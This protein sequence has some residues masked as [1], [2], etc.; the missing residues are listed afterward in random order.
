MTDEHAFADLMA[1]L[2]A[3][4]E[5]VARLVVERF[6]GRLMALARRRLDQRLRRKVDPED[7]LQSVYKSFFRRHAGGHFDLDDWDGLWALLT[8]FTVRKCGQ[9][10]RRFHTGIRDVAL[11]VVSPTASRTGAA[12]EVPA[13][14]PTP[15]EVAIFGETLEHLFDGL[16]PR[17]QE[18][19]SLSLQGFSVQEVSSQVG[20]TRRTVQRVLKRVRDRL[21][22]LRDDDEDRLCPE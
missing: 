15:S 11:E 1:R 21:E 18:I 19:V 17:E 14:D 16:D 2:R 6:A 22:R 4:D 5:A 10:T 20:R 8:V 9:W 3:G 12:F 7:V 13:R